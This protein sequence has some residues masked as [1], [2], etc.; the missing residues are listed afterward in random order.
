M[1]KLH[2]LI[3]T[4][5]PS[6]KMRIAS[7]ASVKGSSLYASSVGPYHVGMIH[8]LPYPSPNLLDNTVFC[9]QCVLR[10]SSVGAAV[11]NS[12][13]ADQEAS[14]ESYPGGSR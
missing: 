13:C 11:E 14:H 9:T 5:L 10:H 1:T 7:S 4:D 12:R 6:P 3:L 8:F 2:R